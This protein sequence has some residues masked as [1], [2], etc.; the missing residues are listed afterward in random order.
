MS[1]PLL[2][3]AIKGL[4]C[5]P[6][7]SC[8]PKVSFGVTSRPSKTSLTHHRLKFSKRALCED[9]C[10]WCRG[11]AC[12]SGRD[13]RGCDKTSQS[14]GLRMRTGCMSMWVWEKVAWPGAQW[15]CTEKDRSHSPALFCVVLVCNQFV[16]SYTVSCWVNAQF[17][18]CF[19]KPKIFLLVIPGKLWGGFPQKSG[20]RVCILLMNECWL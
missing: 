15:A 14:D 11:V 4:S 12:T 2:P 10:V 7:T 5:P 8:Y 1:N 9:L 16:L 17:L 19:N 3:Q 13:V 6:P 18:Y 20:S